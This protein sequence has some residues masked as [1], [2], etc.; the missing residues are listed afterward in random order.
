MGT[1]LCND[2][3]RLSELRLVEQLGKIPE[4]ARCATLGVALSHRRKKLTEFR[5]TP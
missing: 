4:R 3:E 1:S 2:A 5:L